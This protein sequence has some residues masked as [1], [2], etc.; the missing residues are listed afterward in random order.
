M[1]VFHNFFCGASLVG[2]GY[3]FG[4]FNSLESQPMQAQVE[5]Q[6]LPSKEAVKKIKTVQ[7]ELKGA[8]SIL[9]GENRYRAAIQNYNAFAISVGGI[10]AIRDLE[11]GRGVDPETFAGLYAD[12]ATDEVAQDLGRDEQG[13]LTYKGRVIRMYSTARL[14]KHFELRKKIEDARN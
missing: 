6:D 4:A 13:R 14:K 5:D 7:S 9:Q 10:D 1:A 11:S 2:F 8:M 12:Q 3:L